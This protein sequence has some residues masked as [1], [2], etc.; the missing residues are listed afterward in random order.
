MLAAL[1]RISLSFVAECLVVLAVLEL[2]SLE[3][4]PEGLLVGAA[5]ARSYGHCEFH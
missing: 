4:N 5:S 2:L 3:R 1:M